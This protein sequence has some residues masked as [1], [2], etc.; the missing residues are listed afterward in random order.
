LADA[1]FHIAV[2]E[3]E[4]RH[5]VEEGNYRPLGVAQDDTGEGHP[6]LKLSAKCGLDKWNEAPEILL[7][8]YRVLLNAL[9]MSAG[10]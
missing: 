1:G 7:D 5:E 8:L 2:S 3:D 4:W 10:H 9:L 6:F